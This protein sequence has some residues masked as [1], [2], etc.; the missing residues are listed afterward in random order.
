MYKVIIMGYIYKITN[1]INNKVYIGQTVRNPLLR[2]EEHFTNL[3]KGIHHSSHLQNSFDKYGDVF[4]FEVIE[5]CPDE[6]LNEREI[7]LIEKFKS[8]TNGY[9]ETKGGDGFVGANKHRIVKA[10]KSYGIKSIS[11]K[12]IIFY[13]DDIEFLKE[14][15]YQLRVGNLKQPEVRKM[16]QNEIILNKLDN[17]FKN[18]DLAYY[19][20]REYLNGNFTSKEIN[21]IV[22]EWSPLTTLEDFKSNIFVKTFNHYDVEATKVIPLGEPHFIRKGNIGYQVREFPDY[23]TINAIYNNEVS[24]TYVIIDIEGLCNRFDVIEYAIGKYRNSPTHSVTIRNWDYEEFVK[25]IH[26]IDYSE[27]QYKEN[28]R[29]YKRFLVDKIL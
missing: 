12:S 10:G 1:T 8:Y 4:E 28:G 9:N 2:K 3:R 13:S 17:H 6:K 21:D 20:Y 22:W 23:V 18:I 15:S 7:A 25:H 5:E 27:D 16:Y 14:L 29:V 11:G 24:E 26:I 19:L